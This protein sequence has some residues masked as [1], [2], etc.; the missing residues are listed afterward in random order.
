MRSLIIRRN[1]TVRV[2]SLL[3]LGTE[4]ENKDANRFYL[5]NFHPAGEPEAFICF[6]IKGSA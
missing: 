6:V 4:S 5:I 1:I 3:K 2:Q